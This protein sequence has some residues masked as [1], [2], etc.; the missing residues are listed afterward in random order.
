MHSK[1]EFNADSRAADYGA[2]YPPVGN[3]NT[4]NGA[5]YPEPQWGAPTF[6]ESSQTRQEAVYGVARFS[7]T[8]PLKA[9][10]GARVTNYDKTG[11]GAWS[12]AY[13]LKHDHQLTPYAGLVYDLTDSLS[14]YAS[15]TDIFQPQ[16]RKDLAGNILDPVVGKSYETGV[17][18][19]FL[20]GRVQAS[21]AVF[22]IKQDKLAQEAGLIDRD[23]NGPLAPEAYYRAANGAK[24]DGFEFEMSGELAR[25][26]NATAGYSQFKAKDAAGSD[27]NSV[28]PRKLF[29]VFT[30][31]RLEAL[32]VGGGVNWESRTYTLDPAAPAGTNGLIE[33]DSF[34]LASLMARY[35]I[36]KQL[37]A[38]VNVNNL[39]DKKHFGMFA[40]Y[41]AITYAAPRSVSASLKYRF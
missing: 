1:Q 38:Q 4:W 27:I 39:F 33:Q 6:Y 40:A 28:Y 36:T 18:G 20:D 10:V 5:A 3:F 22:K 13:Q 23:G 16:N 8:D 29:R 17:K 24:S 30:T 14:A 25:G 34:A 7:I 37:S 19:E 35:E 9:I 15:Y 21:L 32:T 41:G 11:V 2:G 26:W 12:P 31:Y